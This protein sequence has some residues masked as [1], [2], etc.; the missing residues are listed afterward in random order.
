MSQLKLYPFKLHCF[1]VESNHVNQ[2]SKL[3]LAN[4]FRNQINSDL[5]SRRGHKRRRDNSIERIKLLPLW[6]HLCA[7]IT[8]QSLGT[9]QQSKHT[10][11]LRWATLI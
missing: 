2:L 5:A 7:G 8:V 10:R 1:L 6:Q 11:R 3:A 9:Q 4:L